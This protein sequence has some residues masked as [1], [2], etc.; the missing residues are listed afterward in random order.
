MSNRANDSETIPQL[1]LKDGVRGKYFQRYM[2]G[3]NVVLLEPDV[4]SKFP[5]A[6]VVNQALRTFLAEHAEVVEA[7]QTVPES[8]IAPAAESEEALPWRLEATEP[9]VDSLKRL[10]DSDAVGAVIAGLLHRVATAPLSAPLL[11][12]TR[13]QVIT[14]PES[15]VGE[16]SIPSLQLLYVSAHS[17]NRIRL[18]M[19]QRSESSAEV[20]ANIS[21][22]LRPLLGSEQ[23][24]ESKHQAG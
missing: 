10:P 2:R 11:A 3:S 6:A 19:I 13:V 15:S 8:V 23:F 22:Q 17:S 1:E 21:T 20:P 9:F 4:A 14:L 7:N 5:D 12:G 18:L 24:L 16:E